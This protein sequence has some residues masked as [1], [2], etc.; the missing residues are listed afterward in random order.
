MDKIVFK[1]HSD[2][3][4]YMLKNAS[5]GN[6]VYAVLFYED[7]RKLLK[8]LLLFDKTEVNNIEL[9]EPMWKRYDKEFY[10]VLDENFGVDI[11]EAYHEKNKYH[12][13]G[14]Y[15]FGDADI[16]NTIALMDGEAN[17]KIIAAAGKSHCVEIEINPDIYIKL[18][19][20]R[21]NDVISKSFQKLFS[22]IL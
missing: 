6:T 9:N 13:A 12:D 17:S 18:V 2:L 7:A 5:E 4:E 22:C 16:E 20:E 21:I 10:V 3:A 15:K 11:E 1:T 8:E 14:Y 19:E